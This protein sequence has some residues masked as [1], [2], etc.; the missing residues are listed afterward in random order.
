M[1]SFLM[2]HGLIDRKHDCQL[3]AKLGSVHTNTLSKSSV[4]G[5]LRFQKASFSE[6]SVFGKL[7]FRK[8]PFSE[9][10]EYLLLPPRSAL[11][12]VSPRLRFSSFSVCL[13]NIIKSSLRAL[14]QM[15]RL[16]CYINYCQ[17]N[18]SAGDSLMCYVIV[19]K[20][21]RFRP[22]IFI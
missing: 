2:N 18:S 15:T 12:A 1:T 7:R 17:N 4:F 5:G 16:H 13:S 19:F 22:R 10:N 8:A 21:L 20:C 14:S 9:G 3:Y 6:S 11:E